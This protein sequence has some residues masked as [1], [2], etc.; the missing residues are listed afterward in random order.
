MSYQLYN[1]SLNVI[2]DTNLTIIKV[3]HLG[4]IRTLHMEA[5]AGYCTNLASP[6]LLYKHITSIHKKK[7]ISINVKSFHF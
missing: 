3:I 4:F 2:Y 6:L 5:N 1:Y 7:K